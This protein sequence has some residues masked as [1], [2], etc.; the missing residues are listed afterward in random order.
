ML[1]GRPWASIGVGLKQCPMMDVGLEG[2]ACPAHAFKTSPGRDVVVDGHETMVP[3]FLL[4]GRNAT[5]L[6]EGIYIYTQP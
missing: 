2:R 3:D 6:R 5:E 1:Y 4:S